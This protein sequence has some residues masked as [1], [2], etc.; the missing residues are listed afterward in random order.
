MVDVRE[1]ERGGKAIKT[2]FDLLT[3]NLHTFLPGIIQSFDPLERTC[4]VQPSLKRLYSGDEEPTNLPIQEDVPVQFPGSNGFYLEFRLS[5]GDE[6]ACAISERSLEAWLE[7]GGVVDPADSRR[8]DLSD[9]IVIAG[10]KTQANV[11]GE[12]GEG[13]A[14][15]NAEGTVQ[16]RAVNDLVTVVTGDTTLECTVDGVK[17]KP[18]AAPAVTD[19]KAYQP[20]PLI[21][22]DVAVPGTAPGYV[23]IQDHFHYY[24]PVSGTPTPTSNAA[25]TKPNEGP[26]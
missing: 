20:T 12:V 6:V 25:L 13:I 8:F 22:T 4:S 18:T 19:V 5:K 24:L 11:Q 14:L 23:T 7:L 26:P 15:R 3:G 17:A 1:Q 10:M 16:V 2:I 21:P 9:M